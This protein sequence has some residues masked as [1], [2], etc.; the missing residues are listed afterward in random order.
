MYRTK[1]IGWVIIILVMLVMIGQLILVMILEDNDQEVK[2]YIYLTIAVFGALLL[3]FYRLETVIDQ[4][5]IRISFG[6]GLI[7]KKIALGEIEQTEAVRNTFWYGWGIRLTPHGWMW[8]IA[9][10]DAVQLTLKSGKKFRIGT[11][12]AQLLKSEIDK[13]L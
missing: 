6:I 9:G 7:K 8:N 3:L 4:T 10:Y 2:P 13:R 5:E 12:N 1:Q 11:D